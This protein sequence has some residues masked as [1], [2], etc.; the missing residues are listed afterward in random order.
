MLSTTSCL[1]TTRRFRHKLFFDECYISV[2]FCVR[3]AWPVLSIL[4]I[5]CQWTKK[6]SKLRRR[7]YWQNIGWNNVTFTISICSVWLIARWLAGFTAAFPCWWWRNVV[8][9][10]WRWWRWHCFWCWTS[11]WTFGCWRLHS[12]LRWWCRR[13]SLGWW[14]F[15]RRPRSFCSCMHTWSALTRRTSHTRRQLSS[16]QTGW[17]SCF[18]IVPSPFPTCCCLFG[19][20]LSMKTITDES[21]RVVIFAHFLIKKIIQT[22]STLPCIHTEIYMT[23]QFNTIIELYIAIAKWLEKFCQWSNELVWWFW[24]HFLFLVWPTL[25]H[26][27]PNKHISYMR[28]TLNHMIHTFQNAMN[29]HSFFSPNSYISRTL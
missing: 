25:Q 11:N 4:I 15:Q 16:W 5:T 6:T 28:W 13:T 20:W 22:L 10:W 14:A 29:V 3:R 8:L 9:A 24:I 12:S 27:K 17:I 1:S 21:H 2:W 26:L 19:F 23:D 7:I 18:T